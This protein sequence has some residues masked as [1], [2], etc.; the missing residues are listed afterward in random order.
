MDFL[1]DGRS[2]IDQEAVGR[3]VH[4]FRQRFQVVFSGCQ[5]RRSLLV[6]RVESGH[7]DRN[8]PR[9]IDLR[10]LLESID[11]GLMSS[12]VAGAFDFDH[13]FFGP[14]TVHFAFE[15]SVAFLLGRQVFEK[16]RQLLVRFVEPVGLNPEAH[17]TLAL[18][19][20]GFA[21]LL[22][23]VRMIDEQ[24]ANRFRFEF[25]EQEVLGHS[26]GARTDAQ[27]VRCDDVDVLPDGVKY[28]RVDILK[29]NLPGPLLGV[30]RLEQLRI[31]RR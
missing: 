10:E 24:I 13:R 27:I 16:Q 12:R 28:P 23:Q 4:E 17:E 1:P 26:V 11:R 31:A 9:D 18:R 3:G 6:L 21:G 29:A 5:L 2:P 19:G 30:P 8:V 14:Q 25:F 20:I 7:L 15:P 22:N